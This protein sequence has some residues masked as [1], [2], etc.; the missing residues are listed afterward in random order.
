[1]QK[2]IHGIISDESKD[3]YSQVL[4]VDGMIHRGA[5]PFLLRHKVSHYYFPLGSVE[6]ITI[7]KKNKRIEADI[8]FSDNELA[9]MIYNNYKKVNL[10]LYSYFVIFKL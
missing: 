6:N 8:Y 9:N 7:D 3:Y 10:Y 1:M 4:K 2:W 5:I